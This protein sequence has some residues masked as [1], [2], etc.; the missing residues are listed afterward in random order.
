M[1]G[2]G[3]KLMNEIG[4]G[5]SEAWAVIVSGFLASG[6][7]IISAYLTNKHASS[8]S[9][10]HTGSAYIT[11]V[12]VAAMG[13]ALTIFG[14]W[15]MLVLFISHTFLIEYFGS[16]FFIALCAYL[17]SFAIGIL[18]MM[19]VVIAFSILRAK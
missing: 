7:V 19:F 14:F 9:A 3:A 18:L 8:D 5:L 10:K 13:K 15:L 12:K 1:R 4:N 17:S 11:S 16:D 6:S 2:G